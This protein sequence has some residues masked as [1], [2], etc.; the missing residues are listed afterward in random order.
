MNGLELNRDLRAEL[1]GRYVNAFPVN[2]GVW[3]GRVPVNAM[4][5]AGF[6]VGMP[7]TDGRGL[8]AGLSDHFGKAA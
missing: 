3:V 1:R 2:D 4:V 6:T 5:D 7:G 8:F